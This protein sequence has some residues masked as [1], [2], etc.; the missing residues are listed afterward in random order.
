MTRR[1]TSRSCDA[2]RAGS[3]RDR[4]EWLAEWR[5]NSGTLQGRAPCRF[6]LGA[7]R[8]AL[9]LRRNA[10]RPERGRLFYPKSALR[11]IPVPLSP[12]G[13]EPLSLLSAN[14]E[15]PLWGRRDRRPGSIRFP[16]RL[17]ITL[18]ALV[19]VR[20]STPLDLGEYPRT[21]NVRRW[22]FLAIKIRASH[23]DRLLRDAGP[24]VADQRKPDPAARTIVRLHPGISLGAEGPAPALP[25]V[26]ER[27]DQPGT[28]RHGLADI[29]GM[30]RHRAHL[31]EGARP[32]ACSGDPQQ[33]LQHAAMDLP[34]SLVA[35]PIL[36]DRPAL[37]PQ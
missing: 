31:R 9:W 4:P 32:S 33:L 11:C 20:I 8:D 15:T 18:L 26:P 36:S 28:H 22:L 6:C 13:G 29:S 30:V 37:R 7:F 19:I 24:H 34:R 23:P 25:G 35:G 10:P 3:R 1:C 27:A 2:P 14:T 17:A 5:P 21:T 16:S 12:G